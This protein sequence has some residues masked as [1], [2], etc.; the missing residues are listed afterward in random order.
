MKIL[1]VLL[2]FTSLSYAGGEGGDIP[3]YSLV[4]K[5]YWAISCIDERNQ[6]AMDKCGELSLKKATAAMNEL[7][8]KLKKNYK[9]QEPD[10]YN[11]LML[12][13][14]KWQVHMK[15]SCQVE[16]YYSREGSAY[17]SILNACIEMKTNERIS[18]LNG[19]MESP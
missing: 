3:D 12:S 16:T 2:F 17:N 9:Y 10:L 4:H 13:Q 6:Q 8:E 1:Y 15:L 11:I 14:K 7:L 5:P 19:M 18:Y